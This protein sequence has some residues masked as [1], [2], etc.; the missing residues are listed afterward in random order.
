MGWG[1][2]ITKEQ[3]ETDR[4]SLSN[5]LTLLNY[6]ANFQGWPHVP[7]KKKSLTGEGGG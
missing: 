7:L 2:G 6:D 1:L 3:T 4:Y 5:D